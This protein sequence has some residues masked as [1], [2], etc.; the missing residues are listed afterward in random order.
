ML[1]DI[2]LWWKLATWV[3]PSNEATI[4]PKAGD[5]WSRVDIAAAKDVQSMN[6][7]SAPLSSYL[8]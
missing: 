5:G 4:K 3:A 7:N 6:V 1:T 2:H 8:G